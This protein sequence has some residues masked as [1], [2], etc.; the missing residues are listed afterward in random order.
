MRITYV[1]NSEIPSR[2]ANSVQV[3]KMCQ[4]MAQS[5]HDVTLLAPGGSVERLEAVGS[6]WHHY[7]VSPAFRIRWLAIPRSLPD[8]L[9]SYLYAARAAAYCCSKGKAS[10]VYARHLFGA[11]AA[12]RMRRRVVF[13]A[14]D[15][16]VTY[17]RL[18]P[19]WFERLLEQ[20][21]LE[22]LV[23]TTHALQEF[24]DE[25]W[26]DLLTGNDV[27]VAPNGVDLE[28]FEQLPDAAEARRRLGIASRGFVAGYAGQ[29]YAGRGIEVLLELA[30]RR[31]DIGFLVVGGDPDAVK[32][33]KDAVTRQQCTNVTFT[34]FVASPELPLLLAA[35]D[36]LLMPYQPLV[37]V[38]GGRVNEA[39][40]MSPLKV[41]EYLASGRAILAS[42]LPVLR[43]VLND[44]NA[45]LV[46]ATD[47]DAWESALDRLTRDDQWRKSLGTQARRD[48]ERYTWKHRV[49]TCLQSLTSEPGRA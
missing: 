10:L 30:R 18:G 31:S 23:V 42:R 21:S 41:F 3:M 20:A 27:V 22:R 45:V 12:A 8:P 38:A 44:D 49:E 29:L 25:R 28:R 34:G 37:T 36:A 39:G 11:L 7:G 40:W 47:I 1:S 9:P 32:A 35:C 4:A 14:H 48:A 17:G 24:L 5:G 19:R 2:T 26:P 6:V 33:Y 15:L 43:E 13:E 46:N 16:P